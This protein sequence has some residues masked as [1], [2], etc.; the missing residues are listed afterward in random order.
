MAACMFH[1][2]QSTLVFISSFYF[3]FNF[4]GHLVTISILLLEKLL[5]SWKTN[6][7]TQNLIGFF[8]R[9]FNCQSEKF[10]IFNCLLN[11]W[12]IFLRN[13]SCQPE[14]FV[15]FNCL[16]NNWCIFSLFFLSILPSLPILFKDHNGNKATW[17]LSLCCPSHKLI[18]DDIAVLLF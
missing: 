8:L 9:N 11:N 2:C 7:I 12:C 15:I 18:L 5:A 3:D 17:M 13:F 1:Y 16:L 10:V 4:L 6:F 14:K